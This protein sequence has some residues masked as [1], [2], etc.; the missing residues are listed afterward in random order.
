MHIINVLS[1]LN[2][3]KRCS[4]DR[5]I[6]LSSWAGKSTS[7]LGAF[8]LSNRADF[9]KGSSGLCKIRKWVEHI[10]SG[11]ERGKESGYCEKENDNKGSKLAEASLT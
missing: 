10:M 8:Y 6:L 4:V 2:A 5:R 7:L 11:L 1:P 9:S 3:R